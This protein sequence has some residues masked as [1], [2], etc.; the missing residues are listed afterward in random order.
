MAEDW[1][2][3]GWQ[4]WPG[5]GWGPAGGWLGVAGAGWGRQGLQVP[6]LPAGVGEA[7]AAD[8]FHHPASRDEGLW[9]GACGPDSDPPPL[10]SA[11]CTCIPPLKAGEGAYFSAPGL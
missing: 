5:P 10:L 11:V 4:G 3:R 6:T 2:G 9:Q 1:G 8:G 7:G